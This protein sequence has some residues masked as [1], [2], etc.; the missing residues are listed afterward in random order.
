MKDP[1]FKS[2][3]VLW[4]CMQNI[5]PNKKNKE[6]DFLITQKEIRSINHFLV[7]YNL[8]QKNE[9]AHTPSRS[10]SGIFPD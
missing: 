8:F 10:E 6:I 4:K 7:A 3:C 5:I 2:T 9:P 1:F